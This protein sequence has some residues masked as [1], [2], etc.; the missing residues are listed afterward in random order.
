MRQEFVPMIKY[1]NDMNLVPF[2]DFSP[3][4]LNIFFSLCLLMKEKGI[5]EITLYYDEIKN[6]IL[7]RFESNK[8]FEEILESVY[9]KLLQLRIEFRGNNKIEKFTLFTSYEIHRIE[10]TVT[11]RTNKDYSYIL[12]N[13][14]KNFTL[15]ELQE[16]NALASSYSKNMFRLLK[17]YKSTGFYRVSIEE[18]RRLLDIPDSYA[19]KKIGVKV[20]APIEK[21]LSNYFVDLKIR[22]V[23][24]GRSIKYLE[25]TFRK[26][27]DVIA[28][29]VPGVVTSESSLEETKSDVI[30]PECGKPLTLI[31]NNKSSVNFWGHS[32][33]KVNAC[34]ATYS[35][36]DEIKQVKRIKEGEVEALKLKQE[37]ETEIIQDH[38]AKERF[39]KELE[40]LIHAHKDVVRLL[41]INSYNISIEQV[42]KKVDA[43][44]SNPVIQLKINNKTI[45]VV[46]DYIEDWSK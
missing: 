9:D 11:I 3:R 23:K 34:K 20:L 21:E 33:Y 18:F 46:K 35:S 43:L 14:S 28:I 38:L 22:K 32:D 1:H 19:M 36:L 25:F 40:T 6:V 24:S 7:D 42:N 15:F 10:K 30:C 31:K 44:Y 4:E 41:D 2:K 5:G 27:T 39:K 16:F 17:Q 29:D 26:E 37:K 12:N 45:D 13:L 8:R